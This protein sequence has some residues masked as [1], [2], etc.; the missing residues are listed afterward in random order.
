L[1][2]QTSSKEIPKAIVERHDAAVAHHLANQVTDPASRFFGSSPDADG[3]HHP[4]QAAGLWSTYT[5]AFLCPQSRYHRQ[6]E[7]LARMG[8]T[9]KFVDASI[10]AEGNLYSPIT[11]FNSPPDTAFVVR[12]AAGAA[13]LARQAN[14][15]E[16]TNIV[17]PRLKTFGRGLVSGGIHTPNHRWVNC[18][19]M[20]QLIELFPD[21]AYVRRIDQ[22][23]AEGF[24]IDSDGQW[25]E[26]S[27]AMYNGHVNTG[28]IVMA[29]KL[30]RPE[31]LD[32]VRRNLEAMLYLLHDN[33]EVDT[34]FSIRQD[35]DTAGSLATSWFGIQYFA[36]KLNDRRFGGVAKG[37]FPKFASL[38]ELMLWPELNRLDFP[39]DPPPSNYVR[40][41][42]HNHFVRIRRG[43]ASVTLHTKGRDRFLTLRHGE[44]MIHAVR[45]ATAFFGKAQF[46]PDSFEKTGDGWRLTQD[47][48]GPYYQPFTPPRQIGPDDWAATQKLRS[49]SEVCK[50]RQMATVSEL[51][52]GIRLVVEAS[53]TDMVPLAIE[54]CP[55]QPAAGVDN[56]L[57]AAETTT[58]GGTIR[59]K[60]GGCEHRY[61]NVRG[62]L[63]RLSPLSFYITGLTPF[64]RTIDFTWG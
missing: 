9:T 3:L 5:T 62:A 49:Q 52:N 47:L 6:R 56:S 54:I 46:V 8:A 34:G 19:A 25:S 42:P 10:S 29:D 37:L 61:I 2:A 43:P 15:R 21:S 39:A 13:L 48:E 40:D 24:D 44:A 33:L 17:E 50:L 4:T 55:N 58:V 1:F 11:N 53:G 28:F 22:W 36:A 63:P 18:G 14:V 45:F 38:S 35:R 7:L 41:F 31:L 64:R 57:F 59:I 32:P 20:A 12:G 30:K 26:R 60:G 27:T 51:P 16:I 23:L